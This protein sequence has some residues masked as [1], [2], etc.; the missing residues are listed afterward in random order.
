MP[1]V[2]PP[3]DAP[4]DVAKEIDRIPSTATMNGLFLSA[5]VEMAQ[6]RGAMLPS[7]RA[8]YIGFRPYPLREH[9]VLMVEAARALWPELPM[10]QA[11]RKIGRGAPRTLVRSMI[12]RVVLGSVEG[13]LEILRAMAKAY[14]L[15]S[16]PGSLEV[17]PLGPGRAEVRMRDIHHFLDSH[18]VG[19]FEGVLHYAEVEEPRV[20]IDMR[21][22]HDADLLCTWKGR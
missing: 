3:W 9:C 19:V 5:I 1:F 13:P 21:S 2:D 16:S 11:L 14:P 15:Q 7:A 18:H 17:A 22:V 12:G 6:Q 10:R 4:I 20:L 8:T